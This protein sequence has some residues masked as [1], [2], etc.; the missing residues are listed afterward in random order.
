MSPDSFIQQ[1]VRT[2]QTGEESAWRILYQHYYPKLYAVA[3]RIC[4]A[5]P[6]VQDVIQDSFVTAWSKL[7]QLKEPAHFGS[8]LKKILERNCYRLAHKNRVHQGIDFATLP[9]SYEMAAGI[10]QKFDQPRWQKLLYKNLSQLHDGVL[11]ALLLRYFSSYSS[12]VQIAE[13]LSIPT[14]TV[15]SRLNEAKTKLIEKWSKPLHDGRDDE[16]ERNEW[17]NFYFEIFS[18]LHYH[19]NDKKRLFDHLGNDARIFFPGGQLKFG[20]R[21]FENLVIDDHKHGSWVKP[22][23]VV[24]SGNISIIES[25]HFNSVEHPNHCP[26]GSVIVLSRKKGKADKL[27]MHLTQ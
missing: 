3:I 2:A 20:Y 6:E 21:A 22:V 24:S 13:I 8:W 11:S 25:R 17:N 12:Y 4:G 14:G 26:P 18:G 9:G 19:D 7:P 27:N 23:Q 1:A 10:E 16:S 5:S 15:R